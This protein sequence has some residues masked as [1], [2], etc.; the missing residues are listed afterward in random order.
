MS[1]ANKMLPPENRLLYF[2]HLQG[3]SVPGM[4]IQVLMGFAV[5][6]IAMDTGKCV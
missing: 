2:Q 4:S 6:A 3:F 1:P 5:A